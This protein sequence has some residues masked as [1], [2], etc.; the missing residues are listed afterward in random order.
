MAGK[1]EKQDM[2]WRAIGGLVGLVTAWTAKKIIGFAWEKSTGRKPPV[3]SESLDIGLGEAI[4]Y[5]VVMGVGM[6]VAQ[7]LA[8]RTARKRYNAWKTVKDATR[9]VTS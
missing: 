3:D 1:T 5:A 6:Q 7:I 4:G 2:A 8:A 9:D